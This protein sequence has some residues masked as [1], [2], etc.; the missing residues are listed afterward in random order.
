[1]C[2][3]SMQETTVKY[4]ALLLERDR[5]H[6]DRFPPQPYC[7]SLALP[8]SMK[9]ASRA[10]VSGASKQT[11]KKDQLATEAG[12]TRAVPLVRR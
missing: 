10:V 1:M 9:R 7:A 8:A 5:F 3:N 4:Y 11:K 6:S 12:I 2:N